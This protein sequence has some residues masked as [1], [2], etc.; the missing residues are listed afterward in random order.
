MN[1]NYKGTK[2]NCFTKKDCKTNLELYCHIQDWIRTYEETSGSHKISDDKISG[3]SS[4]LSLQNCHD[5]LGIGYG[6]CDKITLYEKNALKINKMID[7]KVDPIDYMFWYYLGWIHYK[8]Y[9]IVLIKL[10]DDVENV[11]NYD[12]SEKKYYGTS[13]NNISQPSELFVRNELFNL[14][15]KLKFLDIDYK[16]KDVMIIGVP[17]NVGPT[18]STDYQLCCT[19]NNRNNYY[20]EKCDTCS[21]YCACSKCSRCYYCSSTSPVL[22]I[23]GRFVKQLIIQQYIFTLLPFG[24]DQIGQK[25]QLDIKKII[26]DDNVDEF[27][28]NIDEI[29]TNKQD[30]FELIATND[31]LKIFKYLWKNGHKD[32]IKNYIADNE[33]KLTSLCETTCYKWYDYQLSKENKVANKN[34]N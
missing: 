8:N 31:S 1:Y 22:K 20:S 4:K 33:D 10:R 26:V 7:D 9:I 14:K 16:F 12:I 15:M 2:L 6:K 34:S 23:N 30:A 18:Y 21:N 17:Y 19:G 5:V 25:E 13:Y 11:N 28:F 29:M 32:D 3:S 24:I 27:T